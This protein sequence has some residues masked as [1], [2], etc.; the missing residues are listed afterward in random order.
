[1]W[2]AASGRLFTTLALHASTMRNVARSPNGKVGMWVK[3]FEPNRWMHAVVGQTRRYDVVLEALSADERR[4]CLLTRVRL[5]WT[6]LVM[7][8]DL[9][10]KITDI[11]MMLKCLLGIKRRAERTSRLASKSGGV[12]PPQSAA[13]VSGGGASVDN[14]VQETHPTR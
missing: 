1:M 7:L 2:E 5:R 8:F 4:T 3:A 10:V 11:I 14:A 9:L 6:S 12:A 13:L